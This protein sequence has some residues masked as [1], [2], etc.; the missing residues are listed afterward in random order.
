MPDPQVM[1]DLDA[2]VTWVGRSGKGDVSR[3]AVTGFCWG[4][5]MTWL[6]CAHNRKVKAGAAWYGRLAGEATALTPSQPIDVAASLKVP[7]L[8]LYGAEDQGI[9]LDTLERMRSALKAAGSASEIVVYPGAPH[10]F[11]ADYRPS[12]RKQAAEDG[13]HRLLDWFKQHGAG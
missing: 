8:G 3:L 12:Y 11:H 1:S 2:A 5:R 6:Y 10:G 7:V 9:P 4:G 13:W